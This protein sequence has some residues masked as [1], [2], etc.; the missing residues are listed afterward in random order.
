MSFQAKKSETIV[1]E[2]TVIFSYPKYFRYEDPKLRAD[3]EG[4]RITVYADKY[5]KSVEILNDN[6]DLILSDNYFDLNAGCK[7]VEVLSGS[8]DHLRLRSVYDI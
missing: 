7:T 3:V 5:A 4:N 6:E 8:I 2:G 1:S